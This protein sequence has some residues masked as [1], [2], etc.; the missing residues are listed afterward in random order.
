[1][2]NKIYYSKTGRTGGTAVDLDS[3]DGATLVAGDFAY[4]TIGG[5][6]V[7]T[8]KLVDPSA[9]PV[10]S[11]PPVANPGTKRW[12]LLS[13]GGM[14]WAVITADPAPAVNQHG[15]MCNTSG[16][17]FTVTLDAAP[18]DKNIISILDAA[19]TFNTFNLTIGRA[20]K[21]IMG[22]AENMTVST[23][24]ASFSLIYSSTLSD[25]RIL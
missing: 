9:S 7:E 6:I 24:N 12:E 21:T 15:Y 3:I 8:Y 13:N 1:M 20:G 17:A 11:F 25:W 5:I 4:V 2:A 19:S 23:K 16:G 10:G 14:I 18:A 22:L